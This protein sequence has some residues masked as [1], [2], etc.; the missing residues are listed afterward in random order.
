M[1]VAKNVA[2][3][4]SAISTAGGEAGVA[5]STPASSAAE[6]VDADKAATTANGADKATNGDT[7]KTDRGESN[8]GV[9][10]APLEVTPTE[11]AKATAKSEAPAPSRK[12]SFLLNIGGK[13]SPERGVTDRRSFGAGGAAAVDRKASAG[14]GPSSRGNSPAHAPSGGSG[15]IGGE[16]ARKKSSE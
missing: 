16:R 8:G 10:M 1:S 12:S 4:T 11:Q 13:Q 2:S 14:G 6:A 3:S 9:E 15:P 5:K 7:P